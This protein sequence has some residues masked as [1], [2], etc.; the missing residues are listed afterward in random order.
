[1]SIS[2]LNQVTDG[3]FLSNAAA[4]RKATLL[5]SHHITCVINVSQDY[6]MHVI[7]DLE[8]LHF[9]LADLPETRLYDLF[10]YIS[11]KIHEVK[12][13]GGQTLLHCAAGISRSATLCLA[14]L[15]K[16]HGLTLL[17]AHAHLK[18]RR[19]II[20]PNIGFWRQLI[21]Y[22]LHLF[23]KNTV[24]IID[25]PVGPIPDIYETE[26]KNMLPF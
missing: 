8:Y 17:A 9:P 2:G 25:S 14:Y 7:P 15:M 16:Y 13:A 6:R 5:T 21:A 19:P 20:H 1:M 10:E 22:E 3:L 11:H 18:A 24:Q 4:A 23:G 12:A 26:T